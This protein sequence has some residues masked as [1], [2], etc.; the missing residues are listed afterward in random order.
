MPTFPISGT[1]SLSLLS[2]VLCLKFSSIIFTGIAVVEFDDLSSDVDILC[3]KTV[4][5]LI[6]SEKR[7]VNRLV[8]ACLC[9]VYQ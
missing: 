2:S 6:R 1:V 5:C 3:E 4:L 7:S 9:V 8:W